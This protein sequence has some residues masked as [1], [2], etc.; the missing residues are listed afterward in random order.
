MTYLDLIILRAF[1]CAGIV[2]GFCLVIT[3]P[4]WPD[5]VTSIGWKV[6]MADIVVIVAVATLYLPWRFWS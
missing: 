3:C 6:L 5:K 4:L 1:I 2:L